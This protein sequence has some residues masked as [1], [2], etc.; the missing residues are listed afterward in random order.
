MNND[1]F[2][3]HYDDNPDDHYNDPV[4]NDGA[5]GTGLFDEFGY[6][7]NP[8]PDPSE[9][10][11][12]ARTMQRT[13]SMTG[14]ALAIILVV[15]YVSQIIA[16]K[17][18]GNYIKDSIALQM[19]VSS[20]TMYVFGIGSACLFLK[21][22]K[23]RG[24]SFGQNK[25]GV[26]S[27]IVTLIISFGAMYTGNIV[28]NI[29]TSIM[30]SLLGHEITNNLNA[31]IP[32]M[33]IW[34]VML[35]VVIIAPII[36]E[37]LFRKMLID[38]FHPYGDRIAILMSAVFF[39]LFHGNFN[40]FFYATMLGMILGYVYCRTGK[41]KYTI[42]MHM[43]INFCG[44]VLPLLL[45]KM[46][47]IDALNKFIETGDYAILEPMLIPLMFYMVYLLL[48][49]GIWITGIVLF[50]VK[51]RKCTFRKSEL[52]LP[53]K[54]ERMRRYWVNPGVMAA[55]VICAVLMIMSLLPQG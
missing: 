33:P 9:V 24:E 49:L 5:S 17:L 51:V 27:F 32:Q 1:Q 38:R 36:E 22:V 39:G 47:D 21:A 54:S 29:F 55:I 30:S 14:F 4:K 11:K 18:F 25:M 3:N 15:T 12:N 52:A 7:V 16:V 35:L 26:G 19:V 10:R 42:F 31:T 8:A 13:F 50:C 28:G 46:V 37:L 43:I 53:D 23:C 41:I 48:I 2:N 44:S 20:L 34:L 6:P 45:M 40:Q